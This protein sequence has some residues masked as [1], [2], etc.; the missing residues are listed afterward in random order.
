MGYKSGSVVCR[1]RGQLASIPFGQ[2][3]L[4]WKSIHANE[5]ICNF[6]MFTLGKSFVQKATTLCAHVWVNCDVCSQKCHF[7]H[8]VSAH[9]ATCVSHCRN[10]SALDVYYKGARCRPN[11]LL[12]LS[13]MACSLS[14][15]VSKRVYSGGRTVWNTQQS[16]RKPSLEE[17]FVQGCNVPRDLVFDSDFVTT[18]DGSCSTHIACNL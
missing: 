17:R 6:S 15:S 9:K 14:E 10:I 5:R 16:E 4:L 13:V 11:S 3:D 7:V 18:Q 12:N 2:S 1:K 8:H